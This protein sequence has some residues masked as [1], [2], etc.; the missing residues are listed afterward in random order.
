MAE[1]YRGLTIRIGGDTSKL[2]QALRAAD[3]SVSDTTSVLKKLNDAV[4]L[5]PSSIEAASLQMGA[6]ASNAAAT[7]MKLAGLRDAIKQVGAMEFDGKSVKEL[8]EGTKN[9]QINANI[10]R[11]AYVKLTDSLAQMYTKVTDLVGKQA[12][13]ASKGFAKSL[14]E[15]TDLSKV[16]VDSLK[17]AIDQLAPA[18]RPSEEET[19]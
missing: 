2:S 5:D 11:E 7:A 4:K 6:M 12:E 14:K 8:A 15:E 3:R 16:S 10:A 19:K 1:S 18:I 9:A 13:L 17:E